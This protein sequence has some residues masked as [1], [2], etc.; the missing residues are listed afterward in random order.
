MNTINFSK[1]KTLFEGFSLFAI[2]VL[3]FV[4]VFTSLSTNS[5]LLLVLIGFS[6]TLITIIACILIYEE[7]AHSKVIIWFLPFILGG[8]FFYLITS[9]QFLNYTIN[10]GTLTAINIFLSIIYLAVFFL[11][12]WAVGSENHQTKHVQARTNVQTQQNQNFEVQRINA[13]QEYKLYQHQHRSMFQKP[14]SIKEFV[15][16]IEDKSKAI[17]FVIGRV[18]NKYHGGTKEMREHISLPSEWYNDFSLAVQDDSILD[19]KTAITA[20]EKIQTRLKMLE[21]P[22]AEV[23]GLQISGLK[24]LFRDKAGNDRILDVMIRND[25]DPIESYYKGAIEF[26]KEL[27]ERLNK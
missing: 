27:K 16:S 9:Q 18:Y 10:V 22:E 23:F 6:P 1:S 14:A 3:M 13:P 4:V 26:C 19:K 17:N 7:I 2:L 15:A 24:N 25:K 20:V 5:P 12:F 8:M 11:F 21:K